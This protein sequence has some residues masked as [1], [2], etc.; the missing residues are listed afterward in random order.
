MSNYRF[1]KG[2]F[3][4]SMTGDNIFVYGA[5][6]EFRNGAGA[7]LQAR[8]FGALPYGGGRG[9]VGNTY[10]LVTK[11]LTENFLEK[12]TGIIYKTKGKRSLSPQMISKNI[13]ELYLCAFNHP[14]KKFF[15]A[16]KLDNKNL[17]GYTS[18]EMWELFT[19][20]KDVPPNIRFHQSFRALLAK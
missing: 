15:I 9:I 7:A 8:E 5:N 20:G 16:F 6:P 14:S 12:E 3:I 4:T 17:N 10:G 19:Q 1:W 18:L 13:E 2:D 11:N